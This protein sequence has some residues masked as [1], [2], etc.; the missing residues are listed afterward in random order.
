MNR[1]IFSTLD[2]VIEEIESNNY[3]STPDVVLLPPSNDPYASDE[4][5]GD[6]DVGLAGNINLPGDVSGAIEVHNY[7]DSFDDSDND[8]TEPQPKGNRRKW[9]NSANVFDMSWYQ[10]E[11]LGNVV[12]EFPH[13]VDLSELELYKLYFDDEVEQL[14]MDFT[15][16]YG[17]TQKNYPVFDID[18]NLLWDF[19]TIIT[20]S[21]YNTCPQ[22]SMFWSNE[23]DLSSPFVREL[24]SRN[25]FRK[26]KSYLH[27][28]DNNI[29]DNH[30]KWAKLRPLM[31]ITNQKLIQFGVFAEHLS[32]DEQM[33]PYFGR[34]SCKMFIRGKPIRFGYKNWLLCSDD[35][36]PFKVIPYQG[37]AAGSKEPL[38]PKVVNELLEVVNDSKTHDVYFDNFFT[39]LPL[40]E[41]LKKKSI[42]ATGTVR[43]NRLPGLP[44]PGNKEME[45]KERGFMS[46]CSTADVC[47]V[48]WV[49]NKVV[50]VASNYL[51]HEPNQNCKRYSKAMKARI[52]VPQPHLVKKYNA[53]MG[54]VDL[55]DGYLNNLRPCIGGKKWYRTQL[56]NFV[57]IMQVAAYRF[58]CH[59]HPEKRVSQIDFVRSIVHQYVRYD[60]TAQKI[61]VSIPNL[62]SRDTN[63]H[64]LQAHSQGRCKYCQKNCRMICP[65]CNVRLHVNCFPLYHSE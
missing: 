34:H 18:R 27:V 8:E 62:V 32:I 53:H 59:L 64:F 9:K 7:D 19:F 41:E 63:G 21:S 45:K 43:I 29:L 13:L 30:D 40:L 23:A 56:I 31:N 24:M 6:D 47:V 51:T 57:R 4:E 10:N 12:E 26:I 3:T 39:S 44:P 36:Y 14:F 60:R 50:T 52:D 65:T 37:K 1:N 22:F 58:Y 46:I 2:E 49:D 33:V 48:R 5:E 35:G 42:P 55:L 28:C 61:N 20:F 11:K 54:G 17:K 15:K 16:E 38:G 25:N